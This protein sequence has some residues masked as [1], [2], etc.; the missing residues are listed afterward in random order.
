MVDWDLRTSLE[1]LYAAG[2]SIFG[3]GAHSNAA[4]GGRYAGRK[5]AACAMSAS[6]PSVK[7]E[8]IEREKA[9]VYA[10]LKQGKRGIGWKELNIGICKIMQDSLLWG[11]PERRNTQNSPEALRGGQGI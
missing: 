11:I 4:T 6:E 5:A 9:R 8:Q 10:P 7:R 2:Y 3:A 1:G